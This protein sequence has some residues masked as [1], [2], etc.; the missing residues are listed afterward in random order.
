MFMHP[1]G[2]YLAVYNAYTPKKVQHTAIE[3]FDLTKEL[4][5]THE[6][7]KIMRDV[8]E[9]HQVA[10]EPVHSRFAVH[11]RSKREIAEGKRDYS[12]GQTRDG[13]DIYQCVHDIDTG[14]KVKYLGPHPS[15]KIVDVSW[16]P[17]GEMF[18]ICEKDGPSMNSKQVWSN[19]MII[20]KKEEQKA[21]LAQDKYIKF[22]GRLMAVV[23]KEQQLSKEEE[24]FEF[25]KT[26]RH[27][28]TD[29]KTTCI[30]DHFGRSFL[31]YGE[32][33]PGPFDKEKRSI[34]FFSLWGEPL[35]Q[36]ERVPELSNFMFRP[37]P[38]N[39][40]DPASKKKLEK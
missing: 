34:R 28:A 6:K 21:P 1:A 32:K 15:E 19:Y 37:R 23:N 38:E 27:E 30:W 26:A 33:K 2:K 12:I 40:L 22:K 35:E 10:W 36:I 11:T 16:S 8:H 18:A 3:L 24:V 17:A 31:I 25:R 7:L 4:Q 39:I 14:F 5:I 9:F 20:S 13:I 29:A